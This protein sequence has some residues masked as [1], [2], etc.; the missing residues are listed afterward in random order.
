MTIETEDLSPSDESPDLSRVG[1]ILHRGLERIDALERSLQSLD[2][3]MLAGRPDAIADAA[4]AV[5]LCLSEAEPVF[6]HIGHALHSLGTP[7]LQDAARRLRKADHAS[8]ATAAEGLRAAL[9]RFAKRNATCERRAR[10]LSRGLNASLRTL[11]ALGIVEHGRLI[12][13]A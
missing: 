10:G 13:E 8:A 11:H 4:M 7:R 2:D 1:A 6:L 5:E 3:L 12:A 9:K